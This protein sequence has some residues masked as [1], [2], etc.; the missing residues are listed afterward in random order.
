VLKS[1]KAYSV[2]YL[3]QDETPQRAA[4]FK[5]LI[6]RKGIIA[7]SGKTMFSDKS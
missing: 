5:I 4:A 7:N 6:L 2:C 1:A 3:Y